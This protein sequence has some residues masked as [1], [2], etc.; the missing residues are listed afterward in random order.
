MRRLS[1]AILALLAPAAALAEVSLH[2]IETVPAQ[3]RPGEPFQI[4]VT[5]SWPNTCPLQLLPVAISGANIDVAVRQ[6]DVI[7]GEAITPFSVSFD[8]SAAG[9]SGFPAERDYRVRFSVRDSAGNPTLLAFKLVGVD[10]IDSRTVQPEAGFWAPD[11]AGEFV[12][13][14]GGIGFM[15]ER[16]GATLAVTTNTYELNGQPT[17][18]LSAGANSGSAFHG[19]L[20]RSVGGQPLFGTYRGPQF[21]TPVGTLDIEFLS[22]SRA[23]LWYAKA[24]D[25]SIL[26]PLEMTT[27]SARRMNFA[28]PDNGRA[29]AG[30]WALTSTAHLS[31]VQTRDVRLTFAAD[32]SSATEAVLV[33]TRQGFELRCSLDPLRRDGPPHMCILSSG[34]AEI[35]RFDNNALAR[36]SGKRGSD[37]ILMVRVGD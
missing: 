25:G 13:P 32:R 27:I 3:P 37:A 34:G 18:Y 22:D 29:L 12:S 35:G 6:G 19:D 17:W 36:L 26:A 9:G 14:N 31:T 11:T 23:T 16:Q 28:L 5:G 33:D 1:L 21:V 7:C 15:I 10:R 8:P 2:R 30:S 20:L 4:K 24:S